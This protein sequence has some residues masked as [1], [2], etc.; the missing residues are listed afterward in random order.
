MSR[1]LRFSSLFFL[2]AS[3]AL[4]AELKVGSLNC[5][6]L[7]DPSIQHR[8]RVDDENKMTEKQ[9]RS[10]LANLATLTRGYDVVAL[11]E[12]GGRAEVSALAVATGASWIWTEGND[13]AT[14]EEV[15]ILYRLPGWTVTSKGRVAAL[16]KIVSKHVLALA[17]KDNERVYFL[18]VH[19]LRPIGAQQEKHDKQRDVI[20]AWMKDL[21]A[22]E[23][24]ATV[25]V[26]GDTNNSQS[27]PLFGMGKEA[28]E[29]NQFADTH[30]SGKCFDRLVV[31]GRGSWSAIEIRRPPYGD[32]PNLA[33]K[34]VW[35][36]HF[37]VGATLKSQ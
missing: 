7:F 10:K 5:Y 34:R 4:A 23:P 22:R 18:A 31:A 16:D 12:T 15:G 17:T 13:T 33:N 37:F 35:T 1:Y 32:K 2:V 26:L 19:L 3:L 25:V 36:D 14:G 29:L 9:Y 21:V 28:G 8:G 30:L 11:Q 20:G 24:K 6:L 27:H